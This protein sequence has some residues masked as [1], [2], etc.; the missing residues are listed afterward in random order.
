[1]SDDPFRISR[2]GISF[3][4]SASTKRES[5]HSS[6]AEA[7]DS[8]ELWEQPSPFCAELAAIPFTS[9]SGTTAARTDPLPEIPEVMRP[10]F[11]LLVTAGLEPRDALELIFRGA[12]PA[13][14][15]R[16]LEAL[17]SS[18]TS[19]RAFGPKAVAVGARAYRCVGRGRRW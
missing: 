14:A 10:A 19:L 5:T 18:D 17:L 8:F 6:S 1:M 12:T 11:E 15:K 4:C 7:E 2:A 13:E 9:T 16:H 3:Q